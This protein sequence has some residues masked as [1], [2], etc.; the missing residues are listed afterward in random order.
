MKQS[1][2]HIEQSLGTPEFFRN[3]YPVH[4]RL[5]VEAPVAIRSLLTRFPN[6]RLDGEPHWKANAMV[7]FLEHLPVQN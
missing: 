3:P 1:L 5:Q 7:R 2:P 4:G 6:L